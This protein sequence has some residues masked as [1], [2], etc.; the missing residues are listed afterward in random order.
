MG[1]WCNILYTQGLVKV[2]YLVRLE[3]TLTFFF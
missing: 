2:A 3:K 1:E